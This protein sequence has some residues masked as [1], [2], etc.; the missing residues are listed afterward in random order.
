MAHRRPRRNTLRR[1]VEEA[2]RMRLS[3][4]T[5]DH[6]GQ[7]QPVMADLFP[8]ELDAAID[9]ALKDLGPKPA[10]AR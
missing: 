6:G 1:S 3:S 10:P 4:D 2:M 7:N 5:G 8:V 9:K